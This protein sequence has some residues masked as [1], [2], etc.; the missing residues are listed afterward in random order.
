MTTAHIP[1]DY[2][3]DAAPA[4][5]SLIDAV[6]LRLR[7]VRFARWFYRFILIAAAVYGVA[8]LAQR[9]TGLIP[10]WYSPWTLLTVPGVAAVAALGVTLSRRIE[11]AEAAHAADEAL[12]TDDLF[13][14]ASHLRDTPGELQP[15]VAM[16][17]QRQA[18]ESDA[19]RVVPYT[20]TR[21][22]VNVLAAVGV[23]AAMLFLPHFD[24]FGDPNQ[25]AAV[26]VQ[27]KKEL[28]AEQKNAKDRAAQLERA[29]IK[30]E[31]SDEV[32]Q[33]LAEVLKTFEKM[34]MKPDAKPLN[35]KALAEQT[36]KLEAAKRDQQIQQLAQRLKD[37]QLNQSLGGDPQQ[38]QEWKK[39]LT[40]NG[41]TDALQQQI[42]QLQ[43]TAQQLQ[44][45][46]DPA[47]KQQL[48][49]QMKQQLQQM[50][51]FAQQMGQG[52][53]N[54]TLQQAM[55]QL[56]KS[57]LQGL[58]QQSL[59]ALQESLQL[60]QAQAQQLAQTARDLQSLNQAMDAIKQAQQANQQT[61]QEGG[62]EGADGQPQ[63]GQEGGQEGGQQP[64]AAGGAQP[65]TMEEYQQMYEQMCEGGGQGKGEGQGQG[66]GQGE[67]SGQGQGEGSGQGEGQ[68]QGQ[69]AGAGGAGGGMGGPGQGQGGI[70]GENPDQDMASVTEKSRS[71]LTAGK[72]LMEWKEQEVGEA[73]ETKQAY[74]DAVQQVKQGAGEAILQEQIPPGYHDVIRDYFGEMEA[75]AGA[76]APDGG[77]AAPP[78][79]AP[80]QPAEV[81]S[82][83]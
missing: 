35:S 66:Q 45:E 38:T 54:Q 71:A 41:H 82:V 40:Q 6:M 73:G 15:L 74:R 4:V 24:P 2:T 58:D 68:G 46:K 22:A 27:R 76:E 81:G 1:A 72:T 8:V 13:L 62:Q 78:P 30:Q 48:Q 39:E 60:T 77:A 37:R 18:A 65:M 67:G 19:A 61:G 28:E 55:E 7:V 56:D 53:M 10:D 43:Q 70:A 64:G 20:G 57:Q 32:E 5:T 9:L 63:A 23:V 29:G 36:A 17:A 31:H 47:K 50:Q 3:A 52:E 16:E 59:Q 34:E 79:P 51:Q 21:E 11:P 42:Q 12:G 33:R 14:T 75:P 44:Q 25:S 83:M 80:P 26:I 49:Q 69:A